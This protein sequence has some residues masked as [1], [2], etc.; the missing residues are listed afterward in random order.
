MLYILQTTFSNAFSWK[1]YVYFDKS[2]TEACPL[3]TWFYSFQVSLYAQ[4]NI[5]LRKQGRE[6][7]RYRPCYVKY[8]L[9]WYVKVTWKEIQ[10]Y[11]IGYWVV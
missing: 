2:F 9:C 3:G 10:Y 4:D 8:F 11:D 7:L 6:S 1:Q 5:P